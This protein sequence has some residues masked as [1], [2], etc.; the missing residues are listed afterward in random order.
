MDRRNWLK[1]TGI[2]A[3]AWGLPW[4]AAGAVRGDDA[5]SP[6]S[7][8]GLPAAT[9]VKNENLPPLKITDVKAIL[10]APADIR[11][12]VVKVTTSEPGLY[13]LGCATFTQRARTVETAVDKYLRPFLVGKNPLAI[14]DIYQS[15]FVS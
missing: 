7:G 5:P 13:G 11:L 6:A 2:G 4:L 8:V 9:S 15:S 1:R 3:G 12:V 10:T 14:E